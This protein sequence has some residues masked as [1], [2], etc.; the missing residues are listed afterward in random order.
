MSKRSSVIASQ[1]LQSL[2]RCM[3]LTRAPH[4]APGYSAAFSC[5]RGDAWLG[6]DTNSE[7]QRYKKES[8]PGGPG[9]LFPL[10]GIGRHVC[11]NCCPHPAS[12]AAS[13]ILSPNKKSDSFVLTGNDSGRGS[14]S[15]QPWYGLVQWVTN[16]L[17][18]TEPAAVTA[19]AKPIR[20]SQGFESKYRLCLQ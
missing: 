9:Q 3:A 10:L 4:R 17:L 7:S 1:L 19:A 15:H 14:G 13:K 5:S 6:L 20:H 2:L 11:K 12:S 18:T 8:V 16:L